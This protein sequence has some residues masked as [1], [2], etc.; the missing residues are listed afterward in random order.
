MPTR[1]NVP[2]VNP[3]PLCLDA[4]EF[5]HRLDFLKAQARAIRRW[6]VAAAGHAPAPAAAPLASVDLLTALYF[7]TLR[8]NPVLP[9]WIERDRFILGKGDVTPALY[10]TLAA[11]GFLR[12]DALRSDQQN[13]TALAARATTAVAG[14]ELSTGWSGL[15][16]SVAVGMAMAAQRYQTE[17]RALVMLSRQ[18]GQAGATWEAASVAARLDLD[19]LIVVV[20]DTRLADGAAR[21]ISHGI[22]TDAQWR[23]FGWNV[24][25]VDGH[26]LGA[27]CGGLD[28]LNLHAGRPG[29]LIARTLSGKGVS[30]MEGRA[31]WCDRVPS[32][33][34]VAAAVQELS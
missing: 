6:T 32:A 34:D 30:F 2:Q 29:V 10:A 23:S 20:E 26:D 18:D 24:H 31:D 25:E 8:V 16:L 33:D 28:H 19:N 7:H 21:P 27:I 12:T 15:G 13:S 11:R 4:G 5:R 14:V 1:A 22:A 3:G 17:Y 9:S